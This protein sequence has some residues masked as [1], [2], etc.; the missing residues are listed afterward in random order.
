MKRRFTPLILA[1]PL[2]MVGCSTGPS[3]EELRMQQEQEHQAMLDAA[4]TQAAAKCENRV[5]DLA[6]YPAAVE[7][8]NSMNP[9]LELN[10]YDAGPDGTEFLS[11]NFGTTHF[12]NGFGVPVEYRFGCVTYHDV[13]GEVIGTQVDAREDGLLSSGFGYAYVEDDLK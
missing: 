3:E 13:D 6:K 5:A 9:N 10:E 1:I 4:A 11:V 7:F 12:S 8:P 2:L